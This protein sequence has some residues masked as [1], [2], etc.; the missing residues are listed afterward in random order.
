MGTSMK[1]GGRIKALQGLRVLAFIGIFLSHAIDTPSGGWGVSIF[2]LLSGF[3][4]VYSYW[5]R[6]S[7]IQNPTVK[8]S[9]LFSIKK[10][11][12]LYPLHLIMLIV[13]L[14]PYYL[15]PAIQSHSIREMA[16]VAAKLVITIPLIQTWFPV[17]F[18]AINT[19]AWYLSA[20]LFLYAVFPWILK[21]IKKDQGIK[22]TV[23]MMLVAYMAQ[24]AFA[25]A[26]RFLPL[27][28]NA[29]WS[30][31]ILPLFRLGDFFIGCCLGYCFLKR[32]EK[33]IGIAGATI[34]EIVFLAL[35]VCGMISNVV[36]DMKWLTFTLVY[37]PS[38]AGVVY[39]LARSEGLISKILSTKAFQIA[40][41]FTPFAF[42]IHRQVLH[43]CED[44]YK[45]VTGKVINPVLLIIVAIL[46]TIVFSQIYMTISKKKRGGA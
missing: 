45:L 13:A 34:L 11:R 41:T 5:D 6:A 15:I 28:S 21:Y 4:M 37:V 42:L 9:L 35:G 18:E 39:V 7:E 8:S 20:M 2:I 24:F 23:G 19:V 29:H 26:S 38:S 1:T 14:I 40:A 12:P 36:L 25:I 46:L 3:V 44:G 43:Y 30:C 16:K 27:V 31:Y 17:G 33:Q 10:I 32:D 22:K